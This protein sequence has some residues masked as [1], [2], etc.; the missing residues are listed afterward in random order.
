[1]LICVVPTTAWRI[2]C[3]TAPA[4]AYRGFRSNQPL[5]TPIVKLPERNKVS[6]QSL[7]ESLPPQEFPTRGYR[8]NNRTTRAS[9]ALES[10]IRERTYIRHISRICHNWGVHALDT[11]VG[12]KQR[13]NYSNDLSLSP[14][15]KLT[16]GVNAIIFWS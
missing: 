2:L 5:R 10:Y 8:Q 7:F 15:E 12:H 16:S 9:P 3:G 11:R 14:C 6:N 1:M 4:L 13:E